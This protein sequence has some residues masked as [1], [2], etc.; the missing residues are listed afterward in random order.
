MKR[1]H[2]EEKDV[3]EMDMRNYIVLDWTKWEGLFRKLG[4]DFL[5]YMKKEHGLLAKPED[6]PLV[7]VFEAYVSIKALNYM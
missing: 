6:A 7:E 5:K 2:D 1:K 3:V 4:E